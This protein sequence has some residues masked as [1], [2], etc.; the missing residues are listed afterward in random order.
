MQLVN[1]PADLE[2]DS[3]VTAAADQ[4]GDPPEQDQRH[5]GRGGSLAM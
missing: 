4:S 1:R 5:D 2:R 3:A